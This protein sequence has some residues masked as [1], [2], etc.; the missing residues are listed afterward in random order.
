M[1][2]MSFVRGSLK[3]HLKPARVVKVRGNLCLR[4]WWCPPINAVINR[5]KKGSLKSTRFVHSPV[6]SRKKEKKIT[7]LLIFFKVGRVLRK[8]VFK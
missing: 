3:C 5:V 4:G 7:M 2:I 1:V 6:T 8:H